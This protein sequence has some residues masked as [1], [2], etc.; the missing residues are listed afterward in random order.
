MRAIL[1]Y[2]SLDPSGSAISV[3]PAEFR[4]HVAWL[5]SGRVPVVSLERLLAL[6]DTSAAVALTF[7]DA[8]ANFGEVAAPLLREHGLPATLFVVSDHVGGTNRWGGTADPRV[9]EL[10]LLDWPALGRL[11][12]Q[13]ITLGG[14]TRRHPHLTRCTEAQLLDELA[15]GAERM[16]KELG[17]RP[18]EFAYPY[19][20]VNPAVAQA[21]G[22]VFTRAVTTELRAVAPADDP[23]LLPRLDM[24]YLRQAGALEAYGSARFAG[25][26]W[27][28]AQAR[29]VRAALGTFG[30]QW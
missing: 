5:A 15:G 7:D 6:P 3:A 18:V 16:V 9:P 17:Q 28:R 11:A 12:E 19:G 1:T 14:H 22:R 20:D 23:L 4:R 25:T 29:R 21:V 2:H 8:F 27:M 30:G 24:F 10:P 13:G 26:M